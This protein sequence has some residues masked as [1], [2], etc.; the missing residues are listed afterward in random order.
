MAN[1]TTVTADA[2]RFKTSPRSGR[3]TLP[4][5]ATAFIP[6]FSLIFVDNTTGF[7]DNTISDAAKFKFHGIALET[8][9]GGATGGAVSVRVNTEG[10]VLRNVAVASSTIAGVLVY[11]TTN[12][13]ADLTITAGAAIK[14]IGVITRWVSATN[15]DV[16]LFTPAEFQGL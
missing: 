5:K 3:E 6:A 14:P 2:I 4:V 10:V 1:I 13:P 12:N 8:V 11:C 15:C 7:V 16:R 9:T